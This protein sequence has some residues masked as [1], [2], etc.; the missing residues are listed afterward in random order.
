MEIKID[1]REKLLFSE[2]EK[3]IM[4]SDTHHYDNIKIVSENIPLGDIII[5]S[6]KYENRRRVTFVTRRK[7][8]R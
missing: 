4:V 5:C 1:Y 2:L 7:T 8:D 3:Q 6:Q